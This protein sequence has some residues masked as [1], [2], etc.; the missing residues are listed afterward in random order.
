MPG[1][2][3]GNHSYAGK[4]VT[5]ALGA[6]FNEVPTLFNIIRRFSG[7]ERQSTNVSE[8]NP[9]ICVLISETAAFTPTFSKFTPDLARH[10]S[11]ITISGSMSSNDPDW[12]GCSSKGSKFGANHGSSHDFPVAPVDIV[13]ATRASKPER[14]AR[15]RGR[16]L[17]FDAK[18]ILFTICSTLTSRLCLD[19]SKRLKPK[20]RT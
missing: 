1:H 9:C 13:I 6:I 4:L 8:T 15:S 17:I 7:F 3:R 5:K 18:H 14:A 20:F 19:C 12:L 2:Q 10:T 11:E 16:S